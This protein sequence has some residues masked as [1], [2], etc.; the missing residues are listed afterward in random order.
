MK[1][2]WLFIALTAVGAA[3]ACSESGDVGAYIDETPEAGGGSFTPPPGS[4]AGADVAVGPTSP[5]LECEGT[6]CPQPYATCGDTSSVQCGTNLLNDKNNCGACGHA[7]VDDDPLHTT[8]KCVEGQCVAVCATVGGAGL[9][10]CSSVIYQDC[11]GILDDGC[12]A[13]ITDDPNNCGAC[14][15]K[16]ADGE[17]C[18]LGKCGCGTGNTYCPG[19]NAFSHPAT[20]VDLQND[21]LNCGGCNIRCSQTANQPIKCPA[22]LPPNAAFGC[23]NGACATLECIDKF[24]DCDKDLNKVCASNGCEVSLATDPKNCGACGNVCGAGL[25]CRDDGS[26]PQC[27]PP[28]EMSGKAECPGGCTDLLSDP[29]N[30]GACNTVCQPAPNGKAQCRK[31]IC[32]TTC[33]D[34]FGD[35]DGNPANGCETNLANDPTSCG[36]CGVKCDYQ[37]GQPCIEGK[38]L[39][40]EC[41]AG[42]TK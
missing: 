39:M 35:C 22:G 17:V 7:C 16:C 5:L 36:A 18:V 20:C 4:E 9:P 10:A 29:M 27:L 15:N 13:P 30:C 32:E 33:A 8:A 37:G 11:N 34:G 23:H 28:C 40:V 2:L 41:D 42:A 31:G 21:N 24:A 1:Y 3:S 6:T 26:G 25:E 12:E 38:C 19:C 14:G